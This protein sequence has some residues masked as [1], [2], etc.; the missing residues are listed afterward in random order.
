MNRRRFLKTASTTLIGTSFL[1]SATSQFSNPLGF[2]T[3]KKR[4][5]LSNHDGAIMMLEPPLTAEHFR[6]VVKS[7]EG[8]PV[9][10]ICFC[11]G[12]R[13]VYHYNSKVAEVFGQRHKTFKNDWAW[14]KKNNILSHIHITFI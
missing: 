14:I 9:D 13:E 4:R 11:L 12:D 7:Y 2:P 5:M 3:R 8:T 6:E 10:T 1:G